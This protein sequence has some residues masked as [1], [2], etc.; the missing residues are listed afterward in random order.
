MSRSWLH[1]STIRDLIHDTQSKSRAKEFKINLRRTTKTLF[2][3][4]ACNALL[5]VLAVRVCLS[6]LY[7]MLWTRRSSPS[8]STSRQS[9]ITESRISVIRESRIVIN[10]VPPRPLPTHF[11][12]APASP[13]HLPALALLL[14]HLYCSLLLHSAGSAC[15]LFTLCRR[16]QRHA[17]PLHVFHLT[18]E[19]PRV[20][21]IHA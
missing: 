7:C 15:A 8:F 1:R 9:R 6:V 3:S 10:F 18:I 4:H 11:V 2:G 20:R 14:P 12:S 17:L 16:C 5:S 13:S 19:S 21:S